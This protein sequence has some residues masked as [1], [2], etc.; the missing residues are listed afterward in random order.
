MPIKIFLF[1]TVSL[2]VFFLFFFAISSF[3][4]IP[5]LESLNFF[6]FF[7]LCFY[8]HNLPECFLRIFLRIILFYPII[9]IIKCLLMSL[10][11]QQSRWK[12]TICL[13]DFRNTVANLH[14]DANLI[15]PSDLTLQVVNVTLILINN[16]KNRR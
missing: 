11:V 6:S 4:I 9:L 12:M 14:F 7:F 15:Q 10:C 8:F 1:F 16:H 3:P 13:N 2:L 5:S